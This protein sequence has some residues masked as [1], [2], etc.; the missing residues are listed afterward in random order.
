MDDETPVAAPDSEVAPEPDVEPEPEVKPGRDKS[1][2]TP[3]V[4]MRVQREWIGR[5]DERARL[6]GVTRSELM[7]RM[8][9]FGSAHM[10]AGW[11]A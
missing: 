3:A 7:R 10:P 11:R 1:R 6:E 5:V 4:A 8:L 9:M 2:H